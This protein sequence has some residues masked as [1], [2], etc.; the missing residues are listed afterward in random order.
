MPLEDVARLKL[1][2]EQRA[3]VKALRL[4]GHADVV[5]KIQ[6]KLA[7][8]Q[9]ADYRVLATLTDAE[10]DWE[11]FPYAITHLNGRLLAGPDGIEVLGKPL[12]GRHGD[13]TFELSGY[14]PFAPSDRGADLTLTGKD[15]AAD[16]DLRNALPPAQRELFDRL[17]PEGTFRVSCRITTPAG[18]RGATP[19]VEAEIRPTKAAVR[20]DGFPY[21]LDRLAGLVRVYPDGRVRL[22][23]LSARHGEA[24]LR[25]DGWIRPRGDSAE[26]DVTFSATGVPMDESL[27]RALPWPMRKH[28]PDLRPGGLLDVAPSR[29]V[30]KP[31]DAPGGVAYMTLNL[32]PRD[33]HARLGE[34]AENI[35]GKVQLRAELKPSDGSLVLKGTADLKK[36]RYFKVDMTDVTAEIEMDAA[37]SALQIRKL[38]AR[39]YDGHVAG[40]VELQFKPVDTY[41]GA[42]VALRNVKLRELGGQLFGK[43]FQYD[44]R[45]N[46]SLKISGR[47][48]APKLGHVEGYVEIDQAELFQLPGIINVLRV[49]GLRRPEQLSFSEA[50]VRFSMRGDRVRFNEIRLRGKA[51]AMLGAGHIDLA[52][53][54]M[55]IALVV[56][57]ANNLPRVPLLEDVIRGLRMALTQVE[58]AGTIEKPHAQPRPF[59]D[60]APEIRSLLRRQR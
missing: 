54:Q 24:E 26:V 44:G 17:S 35:Q 5:A 25:A 40:A 8:K 1:E 19:Q 23:A 30:F 2:P 47:A 46:G 48:K 42:Q 28:W 29:L 6:L 57:P 13:A 9:P 37:G 27:R 43:Q 21:A 32:V 51:M 16:D 41:Y 39:A 11:S 36:A 3:A 4:R 60:L 50:V 34:N 52:T 53:R 56:G 7:T 12:T 10:A 20:Y 59:T 55:R 45:V 15:V 14:V 33:L 49:M 18:R 31:A 22:E 58:L 38:R